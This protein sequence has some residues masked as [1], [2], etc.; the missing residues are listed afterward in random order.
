MAEFSIYASY[1]LPMYI[2]VSF[3]HY[4]Y[5][6]LLLFPAIIGSKFGLPHQ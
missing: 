3:T 1:V 5:F 6:F 4:L 2:Y